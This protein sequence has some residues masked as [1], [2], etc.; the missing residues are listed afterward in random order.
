M[1]RIGYCC[2]PLGCNQNK[3]K[4]EH[5]LVNRIKLF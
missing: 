3:P 4:K 1:N 5:I 2:I